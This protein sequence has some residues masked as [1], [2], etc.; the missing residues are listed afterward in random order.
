MTS[1]VKKQEVKNDTSSSKADNSTAAAVSPPTDSTKEETADATAGATEVVTKH[2]L[3]NQ[4]QLWY[5]R[6]G[7][8]G[9]AWE[10]N[11]LDVTHFDTVEDFWALYNHIQLASSLTSGCDYSIFKHGIRPMWEDTANKEGGRWLFMVNKR[12]ARPNQQ[13]P[14]VD[15]LWLEVLLCLIGEAF[16]DDSDQICGAVVN[17]RP[18]MDKI[19]I[20]TSSYRSE[21]S[22]LNIGRILKSRTGFQPNI[23]YEAHNDTIVKTG[24]IAR[25]LHVL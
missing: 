14:T 21:Q 18:K 16:G 5:Y 9:S 10:D 25:H 3:Q 24:S 13:N 20:W 1:E 11:L 12:Q 4:W 8:K 17:V 2:P 22:V 23:S 19:S 7:G 6:P 15:E